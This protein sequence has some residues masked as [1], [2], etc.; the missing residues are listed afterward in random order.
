MAGFIG[1]DDPMDI[2]ALGYAFYNTLIVMAAAVTLVIVKL[3]QRR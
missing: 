3:D 2:A 1:T